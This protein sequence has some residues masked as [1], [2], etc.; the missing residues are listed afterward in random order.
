VSID[1]AINE[2]HLTL[3]VINGQTIN[4]PDED[5]WLVDVQ[6]QLHFYYEEGFDLQV[7]SDVDAHVI[8]LMLPL[9]VVPQPGLAVTTPLPE[10]G[11]TTSATQLT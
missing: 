7:R 3:K 1:L 9:S 11:L 2:T 8:S 6:K 4:Q 5:A 10:N